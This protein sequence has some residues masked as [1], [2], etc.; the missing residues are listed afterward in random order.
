MYYSFS[1]IIIL[2][3]LFIRYKQL[4][5]NWNLDTCKRHNFGGKIMTYEIKGRKFPL[6]QMVCGGKCQVRDQVAPRLR[7]RLSDMY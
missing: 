5:K 7:M 6:L 2:F 1:L 4:T 3:I